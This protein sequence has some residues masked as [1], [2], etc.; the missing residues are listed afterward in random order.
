MLLSRGLRF[1]ELT[2][3][4]DKEHSGKCQIQKEAKGRRTQPPKEVGQRGGTQ[5]DILRKSSSDYTEGSNGR[6]RWGAA[7]CL[8]QVPT[9]VGGCGRSVKGLITTSPASLRSSRSLLPSSSGS[10]SRSRLLGPFRTKRDWA[11]EICINIRRNIANIFLTDWQWFV[12]CKGPCQLVN[13]D[14]FLKFSIFKYDYFGYDILPEYSQCWQ[15]VREDIFK[16]LQFYFNFA[17]VTFGPINPGWGTISLLN[18][19][20]ESI[21]KDLLKLIRFLSTNK[22]RNMN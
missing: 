11:L 13:S 3:C 7:S 17:R 14:C 22:T 21:H 5:S 19:E 16:I 2:K 12:S 15:L 4:S 6:W 18:W 8:Y 1:V 9:G 10:R 20:M